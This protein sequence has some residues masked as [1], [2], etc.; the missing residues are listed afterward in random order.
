MTCWQQMKILQ[1]K[2]GA[3]SYVY[4]RCRRIGA[5]A[6]EF[7]KSSGLSPGQPA[8]QVK[9]QLEEVARYAPAGLN[10]L[11]RLVLGLERDVAESAAIIASLQNNPVLDR[12]LLC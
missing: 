2:L 6:I 5:N 1:L 10:D 12:G 11:Q 7:R 4:L 8:C 9:Q 3:S